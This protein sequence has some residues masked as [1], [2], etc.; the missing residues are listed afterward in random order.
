MKDVAIINGVA[1]PVR[2]TTS[3]YPFSSRIRRR[4]NNPIAIVCCK[5]R[6][7]SRAGSRKTRISKPC[8]RIE[9]WV[10]RRSGRCVAHAAEQS[11]D[12]PNGRIGGRLAPIGFSSGF[13]PLKR[14]PRTEISFIVRNP[15]FGD[16]GPGLYSSEAKEA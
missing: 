6:E 2:A 5:S 4:S 3:Y 12:E 15:S 8:P 1:M 7:R 16:F 9:A 10:L 11:V 14:T 13:P